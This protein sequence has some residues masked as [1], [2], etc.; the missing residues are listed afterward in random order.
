MHLEGF[1]AH[2]SYDFVSSLRVKWCLIRGFVYMEI[3]KMKSRV[4]PNRSLER[5]AFLQG[6]HWLKLKEVEAESLTSCMPVKPKNG[7]LYR[8]EL[9]GRE[10]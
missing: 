9:I 4:S 8:A 3:H 6:F 5:V 2:L 7:L 10:W 1:Q